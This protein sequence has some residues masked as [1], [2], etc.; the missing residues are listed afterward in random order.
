MLSHL[1]LCFSAQPPTPLC[2]PTFRPQSEAGKGTEGKPG[3]A[4]VRIV[5]AM[6]VA[7]PPGCLSPV[8]RHLLFFCML[9]CRHA[10][11]P[12]YNDKRL[13]RHTSPVPPHC[14]HTGHPVCVIKS[15]SDWSVQ[16]ER[17]KSVKVHAHT[18]LHTHTLPP[19]IA[20]SGVKNPK[21]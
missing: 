2:W 4:P 9:P 8:T 12:T 17:E 14:G 3:I 6:Q 7:S 5:K 13:A 19:Q 21:P 20:Q 11:S 18:G 10:A 16:L 1:G 15:T